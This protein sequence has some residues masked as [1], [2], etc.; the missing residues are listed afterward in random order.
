MTSLP[1]GSSQFAA[2]S[3]ES[4]C[5][6]LKLAYQVWSSLQVGAK[7]KFGVCVTTARCKWKASMACVSHDSMTACLQRPPVANS[8]TPISNPPPRSAVQMSALSQR[9]HV[10]EVDWEDTDKHQVGVC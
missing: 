7:L 1:W 10:K 8:G 3:W 4:V 9:F 6:I 5:I 2:R